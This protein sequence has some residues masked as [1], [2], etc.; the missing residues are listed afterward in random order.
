MSTVINDF[1]FC[2]KCWNQLEEVIVWSAAFC[3]KSLPQGFCFNETPIRT[4]V[5]S[6]TLARYL[7]T[8]NLKFVK[9]PALQPC[10]LQSFFFIFVKHVEK[11][12]NVL[13]QTECAITCY[14]SIKKII[15][16]VCNRMCFKNCCQNNAIYIYPEMDGENFV[17]LSFEIY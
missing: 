10:P 2:R 4:N 17:F 1:M 13:Y 11:F 3:M 16:I 15:K 8:V 14:S 7:C 9:C 5:E 6:R 12:Y